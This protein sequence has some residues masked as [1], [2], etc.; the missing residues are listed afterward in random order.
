M[1]M[2]AMQISMGRNGT[3]TICVGEDWRN[4]DLLYG[5]T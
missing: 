3:S 4:I 1:G 5:G 2:V